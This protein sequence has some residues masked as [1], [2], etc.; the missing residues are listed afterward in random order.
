MT[1]FAVK[2]ATLVGLAFDVVKSTKTWSGFEPAEFH[3]GSD[4]PLFGDLRLEGIASALTHDF[5]KNFLVPGK[6]EKRYRSETFEIDGSQQPLWQGWAICQML[7]KDYGID[8]ARLSWI[9]STGTTADAISAL[10]ESGRLSGNYAITTSWYH[11]PRAD[12]SIDKIVPVPRKFAAES[13]I[14]AACANDEE[15]SAARERI[16]KRWR[17]GL[18]ERALLEIEGIAKIAEGDYQPKKSGWT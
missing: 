10:R 4:C 17:E 12:D 9:T 14:L 13:L 8:K 2:F 16:E 6:D 11:Q 7:E 15:R 3:F 5:A 18:I 1:R